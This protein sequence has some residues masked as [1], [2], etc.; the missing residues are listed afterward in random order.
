MQRWSL[1]RSVSGQE[2]RKETCNR[3][4]RPERPMPA[5]ECLGV[6]HATSSLS[7][8]KPTEVNIAGNL[9]DSQ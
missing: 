2:H 5:L 3:R 6:C 9:A 7:A 1:G 4:A 8:S